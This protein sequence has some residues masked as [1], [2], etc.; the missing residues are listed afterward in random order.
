MTRAMVLGLLKKYGPMSGYEIQQ[1]LESAQTDQWAYVKP[2][3]IY[4]ALKK[5]QAEGKVILEK[6]EQT[7]LRT[8]S[9]FNITE[10]GKQELHQLLLQSLADSSVVFPAT[11]YTAL[12]FLENLDDDEAITA[13]EEQKKQVTELYHRMKLSLEIK[14]EALGSLPVTVKLIFQNMFDQYELQLMYIDNILQ[15]VKERNERK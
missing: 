2:A 11:L 1:M 13:L 14:T 8:S 3:S 5:L 7:G 6:V 10:E 4:H 15:V 12:T 9:I